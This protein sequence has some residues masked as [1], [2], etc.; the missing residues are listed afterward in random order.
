M[1]KIFTNTIL[2]LSIFLLFACGENPRVTEHYSKT[3][4]NI[5]LLNK[6]KVS[7]FKAKSN[8]IGLISTND[9]PSSLKVLSPI[10]VQ[11]TKEGIYVQLKESFVESYAA[12][13]DINSAKLL[14]EVTKQSRIIS[15]K[16]KPKPY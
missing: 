8:K 9:L 14:T 3:D 4:F 5:E 16:R 6:E 12:G 13:G 7:L 15:A 2:V 11:K 10:R 1:K